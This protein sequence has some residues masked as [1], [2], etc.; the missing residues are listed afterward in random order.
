MKDYSNYRNHIQKDMITYSGNFHF[1]QQLK[2]EGSYVTVNFKE[3][4]NEDT[5][6]KYHMIIRNTSNEYKENLEE[7]TIMFYKKYNLKTGDIIKYLNEYF[8]ISTH[9]DKDN[10]FFDTCK[11]LRCD[12]IITWIDN[13][14]REIICPSS[15]SS[16]A[17]YQTNVDN[18]LVTLNELSTIKLKLMIST[19]IE[20][21]KYIPNWIHFTNLYPQNRFWIT[22]R[23]D[24]NIEGITE[25][26]C[27]K[28]IF[29]ESMDIVQ[30][31]DDI[32]DEYGI[33]RSGWE[34]TKSNVMGNINHIVTEDV[35]KEWG[36]DI[37]ITDILYIEEIEDIQESTIIKYNN[38]FY[39]VV[40]IIRFKNPN[41]ILDSYYKVGLIEKDN[42]NILESGE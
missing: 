16:V 4:F 21:Y 1:Q 28:D 32:E 27:V 25:L 2:Q 18:S 35:T 17:S 42:Q 20:E 40:K 37:K 5:K 24:N 30:F 14:G 23:V 3:Y 31:V 8:L 6:E 11:M 9:I 36:Y 29:N 26:I 10:P 39:D 19:N 41:P 34:I 15:S 7:R 38:K 12:K 22:Q 33:T 13:N